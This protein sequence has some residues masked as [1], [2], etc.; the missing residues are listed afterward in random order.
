MKIK[1]ARKILDAYYKID[2]EENNIKEDTTA[3]AYTETQR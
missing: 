2:V 3:S 1:T